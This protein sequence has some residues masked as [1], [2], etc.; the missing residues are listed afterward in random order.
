MRVPQQTLV[1]HQQD[2]ACKNL[3]NGRAFVSAQKQQTQPG[4]GESYAGIHREAARCREGPILQAM[5]HEQAI[6][7]KIQ[8]EPV[9]QT[10]SGSEKRYNS[11]QLQSYWVDPPL[12]LCS[13]LK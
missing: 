11:R 7:P 2:Q 10:G 9:L 3:G 13:K 8:F 6:D 12:L 1:A 4:E 5:R